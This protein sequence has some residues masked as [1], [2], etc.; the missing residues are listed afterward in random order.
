MID[1]RKVSFRAPAALVTGM[2]LIVGLNAATA[3]KSA[4][5]TSLLII[6]IA[7]NLTD[8]LSVHIYQESESLAE[9]DAFR[10]TIANF[11]ARLLVCIT[12]I[13]ILLMLPASAAIL[14]SVIWGFLL[15]SLL[16]Y[17]LARK[18]CVRATPEVLKHCIVAL[19]V[20]AI[21]RAIGDL[22]VAVI[23]S[24]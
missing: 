3:A 11:F 4:I 12:F 19:A 17:F 21:S 23:G 7:D 2:G 18:R 6:G 16:S 8:S 20:I 14:V 15:L 1:L 24:S 22:L 13:G 10:T 5:I 9:R